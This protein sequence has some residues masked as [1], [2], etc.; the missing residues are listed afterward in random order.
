MFRRT[1]FALLT[2]LGPAAAAPVLAAPQVGTPVQIAD[3]CPGSCS[4]QPRW[5]TRHGGSLYFATHDFVE[6]D[7]TGLWRLA[8]GL[9]RPERVDPGR[10][11][12]IA[13]AGDRLF[14]VRDEAFV[15]VL[16]PGGGLARLV[17]TEGLTDPMTAVGGRMFVPG[18]APVEPQGLW[19]T[20]GSPAGTELLGAWHDGCPAFPGDR[21]APPDS[22]TAAGGTLFFVLYDPQGACD[23]E[24]W[25]SDGTVAGTLPV[26]DGTPGP[27]DRLAALGDA[28]VFTTTDGGLWIADRA[29]G[30]ARRLATFPK[31][32][33]ISLSIGDLVFF[34]SEDEA[35]LWSLWRTDG[36]AEGSFELDP[37]GDPSVLAPGPAGL[38]VFA[39]TDAAHGSEL[40]RTDG[41]VAGTR[42]VRDI[43]PGP[44]GSAPI[45]LTATGGLVAFRADDGEHGDEPWITDGTEA[46][47]V[48]LGDLNPGPAGSLST[49]LV[50]G[51]ARYGGD[52]FFAADDGVTG[53]ELW[54]VKVVFGDDAPPPSPPP[55]DATEVFAPELGPFRLW[56]RIAAAGAV[57]PTRREA[58]CIP[59]T[60]CV[61]GAVPG[62]S[63]LF[64]R[65]VGPKPNGYLWPTLVRFST[66]T[67]EVW[68]E[69]LGT[70]ELRHYR[71][72][73]AGPASSDLDG[74]FDRHG[75]LP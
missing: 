18:L 60:V 40:W 15:E 22:L 71:L 72:E 46:G 38:V 73:G 23:T 42:L 75:F 6:P 24:L 51:F 36:T 56:V 5:L 12:Q 49:I 43:R 16:E 67:I 19:V 14:V 74:L 44:D 2:L 55:D 8:P 34:Q 53:L 9:E 54:R 21:R 63:E 65:I 28:V 57:Q 32:P 25:T 61:S 17:E 47:T 11:T 13:V 30:S 33:A 48:P 3:L 7:A 20:D 59:E 45:W 27:A 10:F 70:G 62:R 4:S 64:V 1:L 68:I 66:S 35:G 26:T 58:A 69:R 52:F 29:P 31:A 41:T 50:Q 37:L 39:R